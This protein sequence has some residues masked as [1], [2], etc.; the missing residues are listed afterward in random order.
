MNRYEIRTT[1]GTES[2]AADRF[3]PSP[4]G[5]LFFRESGKDDA[6]KPI[7]EIVATYS[8]ERV[9]SVRLDEPETEKYLPSF[10]P[11]T[12]T[13]IGSSTP[14]PGGAAWITKDTPNTDRAVDIP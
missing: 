9:V 3:E 11:V 13:T 10:A 4:L 7:Y 5:Y 14:I 8:T 6:E 2:V 1:N 12:V